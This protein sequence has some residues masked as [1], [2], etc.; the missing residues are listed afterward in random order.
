LYHEVNEEITSRGFIAVHLD[1]F[2]LDHFSHNFHRK[3]LYAIDEKVMIIYSNVTIFV[4]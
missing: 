4:Q 2:F 3:R 1:H